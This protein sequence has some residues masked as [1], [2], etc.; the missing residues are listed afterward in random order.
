[1]NSFISDLKDYF[2]KEIRAIS[3]P[4]KNTELTF[5]EKNHDVCFELISRIL[6]APSEETSFARLSHDFKLHFYKIKNWK[7][8]EI[9]ASIGGLSA[10]FEVY[11][12]KIA[13]IK[14]KDNDLFYGNSEHNGIQKSTLYD[15]IDGTLA[16]KQ[17]PR[18]L[19]IRTKFPSRLAPDSSSPIE[20]KNLDFLRDKIRNDIHNA[21]SYN[22]KKILKNSNIIFTC[23]Y[24]VTVYNF[25]ELSI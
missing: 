7:E 3:H 9:P 19:E 12:R 8:D 22:R 1:M 15:L 17:D 16:N 21:T 6:D 24:I 23:Y 4:S 20:W 13:Y 11:L 14:F 10:L 25:N 18:N 5:D 2:H